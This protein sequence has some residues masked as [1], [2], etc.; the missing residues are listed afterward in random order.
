L[1]CILQNDEK[2]V[3]EQKLNQDAQ[4]LTKELIIIDITFIFDLIIELFELAQLRIELKQSQLAAAALRSQQT[5]F[6]MITLSS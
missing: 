4:I 1:S 6:F 3:T 2:T 5:L